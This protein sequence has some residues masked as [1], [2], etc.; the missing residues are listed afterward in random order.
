MAAPSWQYWQQQFLHAAGLSFSTENLVFMNVWN[1]N[2]S[3]HCARNPVDVSHPMPGSTNCQ[4][5][6]QNHRAQNFASRQDAANAFASQLNLTDYP[7]IRE[8]L[9]SGKPY[10]VAAPNQVALELEAWGSPRFQAVYVQTTTGQ[11]I[12]GSGGGGTA[13]PRTKN[14][15]AAWGRLMRT[16]AHDGHQTIT[17]L[18]RSTANLRRIERRL[19]KA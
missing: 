2:A 18:D 14:V 13:T 10:E 11:V 3:T 6:G 15:S 7:A 19:R 12:G 8:A 4:R 9:A 17:E 16:F 5:I 1:F